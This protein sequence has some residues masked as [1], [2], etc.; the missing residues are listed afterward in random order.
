MKVFKLAVLGG[1]V[2]AF[3]LQAAVVQRSVT[4]QPAGSHAAVAAPAV[5]STADVPDTWS[6]DDRDRARPVV[7]QAVAVARVTR[8]A[9]VRRPPRPPR[10]AATG[11]MPAPGTPQAVLAKA[12]VSAVAKA[13]D[14][15]HLSA[16]HLAAIGQVESGSVGGRSV[17]GDHRVTPQIYGPL[18]DGGPFAVV[19]DSDGG[20]YDG[21]SSY[22]RAMGPLQF[23]PGTWRWAGRDGDGDGRRDP[24]N[25]FDAALATAG[26][27]CADGRDLRADGQLRSAILSY[28]FSG[29]YVAAVTD[30]VAF[31]SRHGLAA[32]DDVA[33]RVGS[34]GRASDLPVPETST[35]S[36][37]SSTT[38][39]S[40][41]STAS[42]TTRPA[43]TRT[44]APSAP[45]TTRTAPP[46]R[47]PVPPPSSSSTTTP[48][49]PTT[50]TP[51]SDPVVPA[52]SDTTPGA[53]G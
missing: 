9:A 17:D 24:Q 46:T 22:D 2:A 50:T 26:Y 39:S 13:P 6:F 48:A 53:T 28:N 23:L 38:S 47:T 19:H 36:S 21:D 41:T 29:D 12:Y 14:G 27:L 4:A 30:W 5:L 45:S 52:P 18:L 3:G 32:M 44:T 25:V 8:A 1:L 33:F 20:A 11:A 43:T 7:V 40:T 31:F 10:T 15:C 16:A 51:P 35:T 37:T 34:G 42:T 49:P